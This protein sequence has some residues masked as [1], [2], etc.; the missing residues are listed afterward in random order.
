MSRMLAVNDS[1]FQKCLLG[2]GNFKFGKLNII[3]ET[4][5]DN[6]EN[7]AGDMLKMISFLYKQTFIKIIILFEVR[8]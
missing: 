5:N 1:K 4:F 8:F 3:L 2:K 6:K 7:I